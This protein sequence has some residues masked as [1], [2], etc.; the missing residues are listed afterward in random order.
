MEVTAEVL[1]G[2]VLGFTLWNIA[3]DGILNCEY[4]ENIVVAFADNLCLGNCERRL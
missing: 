3:Y 4:T 1:H 2:F